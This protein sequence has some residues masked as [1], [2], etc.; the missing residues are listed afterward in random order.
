MPFFSYSFIEPVKDRFIFKPA[1]IHGRSRAAGTFW[2]LFQNFH[3][4]EKVRSAGDIYFSRLCDRIGYNTL[5][6]SDIEFLKSRDIPCIMEEDPDNFK[7][8]KV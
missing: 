3:L 6:S 8:G 2:D 4:T 7:Q 5:T 1:S